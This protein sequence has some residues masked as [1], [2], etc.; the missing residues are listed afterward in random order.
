MTGKPGRLP[1]PESPLERLLR[2]L[3]E[4]AP[5]TISAADALLAV[6]LERLL[7]STPTLPPMAVTRLQPEELAFEQ[8]GVA[9]ALEIALGKEVPL[10]RGGRLL[11]EPT[12]AFVAIDVDG[13]GRAPLDAD[14]EAA[15]EI[16]RQ[17]RLRNLGG[18]I[19]VDFVDLPTKPERQRLEEALRKAFRGDPAPLE[20][21]PMSSL[22][23]VQISRAR[24][25]QPLASLF[26]ASCTCCGGSGHRTSPRADA[27]R[28]FAALERV[29]WRRDRHPRR[30]AAALVPG[31]PGPCRLATGGRA[32][33]ARATVAGGCVARCRGVCD[34]RAHH[35]R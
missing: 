10:P 22:G 23:V 30:P 2:S 5:T 17:V 1:E 7:A 13:G 33:G 21:H 26:L 4:L 8:T 28:L 18:T 19:I 20:I 3:I 15:Q 32:P 16:A 35:G 9:A 29:A 12:A 14:L 24:R 6:E 11:I 31:R 25:G 27:E 34:R